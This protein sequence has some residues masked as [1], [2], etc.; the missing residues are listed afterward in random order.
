MDENVIDVW[1]GDPGGGD[2]LSNCTDHLS[3][4]TILAESVLLDGAVRAH[5]PAMGLVDV[6][7][8]VADPLSIADETARWQ[9]IAG[10]RRPDG[11]E[12]PVTIAPHS[13]H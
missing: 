12:H 1:S 3:S 6:C 8:A 13:L 10:T 5:D 11:A 7:G 2:G 4:L 9:P